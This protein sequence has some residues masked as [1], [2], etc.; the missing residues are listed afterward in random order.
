MILSNK[1]YNEYH[2]NDLNMN[3]IKAILHNKVLTELRESKNYDYKYIVVDQFE[4]P[5]AYYNHIKES[6]NKTENITFLTKA[7][8][9][10]LSS[11]LVK[12]VIFLTT[13]ELFFR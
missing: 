6:K 1:E 11:P 2:S 3:K 7:E 10:C 5:K 4:Y 12:N 9:K 8:D 13:L